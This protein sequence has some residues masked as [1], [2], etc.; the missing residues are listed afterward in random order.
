MSHG[1]QTF[2]KLEDDILL[3]PGFVGVVKIALIFSGKRTHRR[4]SMDY[5][6]HLQGT[7]RDGAKIFTHS[8]VEAHYSPALEHFQAS[9]RQAKCSSHRIDDGLEGI[10]IRDGC[11]HFRTTEALGHRL[12]VRNINVGKAVLLEEIEDVVGRVEC[13][14]ASE[15]I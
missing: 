6:L 15:C 4:R 2:H 13:D 11:E 1:H 12:M 8:K 14:L 5:C 3:R 7:G 10:E 9:D